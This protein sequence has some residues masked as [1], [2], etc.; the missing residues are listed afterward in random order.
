[1]IIETAIIGLAPGEIRP[2]AAEKG[3][4]GNHTMNIKAA[5]P[6]TARLI[7]GLLFMNGFAV[8]TRKIIAI[9]VIIDSRNQPD[10]KADH[11]KH[12]PESGASC[13]KHLF[14]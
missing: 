12:V 8:R 6:H 7:E 9:S 13:N 5:L 10:W 14:H 4:K 1:M 3:E 2:N 11:L